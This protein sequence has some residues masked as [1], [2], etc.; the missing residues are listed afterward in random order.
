MSKAPVAPKSDPTKTITLEIDIIVFTLLINLGF[1]KIT[2]VSTFIGQ[3][4]TSIQRLD[5]ISIILISTAVV[6][7]G[8]YGVAIVFGLVFTFRNKN[9]RTAVIIALSGF[10]VMYASV[11]VNAVTHAQLSQSV[12]GAS[13]E[14]LPSTAPAAS[15][16]FIKRK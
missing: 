16:R 7:Y 11:F 4:T 10:F 5:L 14:V 3:I 12:T 6:A 1:L 15:P 2:E 13:E 9:S 8:V